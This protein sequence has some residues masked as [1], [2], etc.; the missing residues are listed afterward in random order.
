MKAA[1]ECLCY[2]GISVCG[3]CSVSVIIDLAPELE[4]GLTA[5][6]EAHGLPLTEYVQRILENQ[7]SAETA[8]ALS[9]SQR[10]ALWRDTRGLP[11]TAPLSDEA[12]SRERIYDSRG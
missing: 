8:R 1:H 3:R 9:P 7:L 4:A 12:M 5:Q 11:P 2:V 6:A 10:A